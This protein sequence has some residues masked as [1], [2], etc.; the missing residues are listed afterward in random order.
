M[1]GEK[2][3]AAT[4]RV[5]AMDIVLRL[6]MAGYEAFFVGGCVRDF[7]RGVEPGDYDIVTSA[8]PDDVQKLF[9]HTV[10]VGARFGVVLVIDGEHRYEV[11]TYRT[12]DGYDDGRRPSHVRFATAEEDVRRRDFTVNGLLLDPLTGYV[13]DLV[14]GHMDITRRIIRTIGDPE[15]RFAEDHL[16]MLRAVRFAAG[17]DFTVDPPTFAAICRNAGAIRKISAER[18]REELTKTITCSGARRGLELL[19]ASGL[20]ME[21]LPEVTALKGVDQPKQFHPEGDVWRHVLQMLDHMPVAADGAM[22]PCLPWAVLLHDVGKAL[23]RFVD[24]SGVHFYG[25]VQKSEELAAEILRRLK[26]SSAQTE[27]ILALIHEHMTFMHV[28]DMRPNRLKRFLRQPA[29]DLH[30]ELHRLDCLGSHGMLDN[31]TF[32]REKLEALPA[33]QLNPPRLLTGKDL[34]ARGYVPGPLFKQILNALEDAQL[35]GEIQTKE[36]AERL[37]EKRFSFTIGELEEKDIEYLI[38]V[39]REWVQ[40]QGQVIEAEVSRMV[41][42]LRTDLEGKNEKIYLVAKDRQGKALGIM[43]YGD[44]DPRMACY[45]S[46]TNIRAS[47]LVIAFISSHYRGKGLGKSLLLTLFDRAGQGG[48]AEM[49]WSSHPRYRNTA[50]EFYTGIAGEPAGMIDDFFETGTKSPIWR[51]PLRECNEQRKAQPL[52]FS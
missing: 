50:W 4:L 27:T 31:Y 3:T 11:A 6:Q 12:E 28:R 40:L 26:F 20:L 21:I 38:H 10:P 16:R 30:L 13:F 14:G 24:C 2:E 47:G 52:S 7:L 5:S 33:E 44:V 49:I 9:P 23:T 39:F 29:F 25:H 22:D 37:V 45:Q 34:I 42:M 35:N 18:I 43:G 1:T 8:R 15:E 17:L 36:E 41:E 51:K 46:A 32:C 19:D 48:Y